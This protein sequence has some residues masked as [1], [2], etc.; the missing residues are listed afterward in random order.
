MLPVIYEIFRW[1]LVDLFGL[2]EG[3]GEPSEDEAA[4]AM[5]VGEILKGGNVKELHKLRVF[6]EEIFKTSVFLSYII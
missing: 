2:M 5:R 4:V 6:L 1:A 3:H